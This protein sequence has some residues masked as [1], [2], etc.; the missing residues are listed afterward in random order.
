MI[1]LE[2]ISDVTYACFI[3]IR[4]TYNVISWIIYLENEKYIY[5]NELSKYPMSIIQKHF[6]SILKFFYLEQLGYISD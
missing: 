3:G 4:N 5:K 1:S 2:I 6:T